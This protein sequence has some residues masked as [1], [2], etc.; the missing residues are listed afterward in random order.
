MDSLVSGV[1]NSLK[2]TERRTDILT[3]MELEMQQLYYMLRHDIT[4]EVVKRIPERC[5]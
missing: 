3:Y 1:K 5:L 2:I 4:K